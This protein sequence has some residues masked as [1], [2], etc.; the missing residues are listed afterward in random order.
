MEHQRGDVHPAGGGSRPD[1]NADAHPN[2]P[3][4]KGHRQQAVLKREGDPRYPLEK[5]EDYRIPEAAHKGGEG[6]ALPQH[7]K[8][9]K[10]HEGIED[11]DKAFH[12]YPPQAAGDEGKAGAAP[13]DEAVGKDEGGGRQGVQGVSQQDDHQVP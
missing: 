10:K 1:D 3:A 11:G 5:T 12:R 2:H 13:G 6:E 8:A 4:G 7:Q 9:Q